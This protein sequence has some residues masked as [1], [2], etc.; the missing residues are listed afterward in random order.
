M[1]LIDADNAIREISRIFDELE[2]ES[3]AGAAFPIAAC[4]VIVEVA[5]K[6]ELVTPT[7]DPA[8]RADGQ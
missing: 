2:A 7:I 6:L 4:K 3:G 8:K 5:L 1:R